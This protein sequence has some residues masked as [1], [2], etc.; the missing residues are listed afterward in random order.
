MNSIF[1]K[2]MVLVA[3]LCLLLT[4]V[5]G[6]SW[7]RKNKPLG[8]RSEAQVKNPF[9]GYPFFTPPTDG[10]TPLAAVPKDVLELILSKL[11]DPED[12]SCFFKSSTSYQEF[13]RSERG[14]RLRNK[15]IKITKTGAVYLPFPNHP[16]LGRSW[17]N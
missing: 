16:I 9:A 13:A 4:P 10:S 1:L 12:L 15:F 5:H 8:T 7:G 3:F 14:K 11:D 17:V 2:K 6:Y